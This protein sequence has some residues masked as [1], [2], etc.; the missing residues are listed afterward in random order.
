MLTSGVRQRGV[1]MVEV[2]MVVAIMAV[3]MAIGVPSLQSW[4][5]N[6]RLQL[7][8]EAV[9]NGMQFARGEA[10]RRNARVFYTLGTDSSWSV[11]CVNLVADNDGDG[12]ADC[13]VLIQAKPAAEGGAG[14]V[15]AITPSA[16]TTATFSGLGLLAANADASAAITQVDLSAAGTARTFRVLLSSGGQSRLCDPAVTTAGDPRLC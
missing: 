8:T 13:P 3:L 2:M 6:S 7:K 14:V 11:G 4:Q 15:I 12:V 1:S 9:L 10:L 16:A 5:A